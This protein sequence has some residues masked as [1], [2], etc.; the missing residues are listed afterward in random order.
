MNEFK[1]SFPMLVYLLKYLNNM[2]LIQCNCRY[3]EAL[4]VWWNWRQLV[5][6]SCPKDLDPDASCEM[7]MCDLKS[8]ISN[9]KTI[10]TYFCIDDLLH[11]GK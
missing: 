11:S 4:N 7:T 6:Q 5:H 1:Y 2:S 10:A 9:F 8:R 3:Y